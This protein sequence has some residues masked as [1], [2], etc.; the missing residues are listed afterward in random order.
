VYVIAR[1]FSCRREIREQDSY[2]ETI[3]ML[4]LIGN[5]MGQSP[6]RKY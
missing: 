1:H 3:E 4:I 5:R 2:Y 6:S